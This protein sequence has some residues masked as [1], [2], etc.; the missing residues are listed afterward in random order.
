MGNPNVRFPGRSGPNGN[1]IWS[2]SIKTI[3]GTVKAARFGR[4]RP[5]HS[6]AGQ[7]RWGTVPPSFDTTTNHRTET[8]AATTSPAIDLVSDREDNKN[9]KDSPLSAKRARS[10]DT[11]PDYGQPH[12]A[13]SGRSSNHPAPATISAPPL[14]P[15]IEG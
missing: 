4:K 15:L 13:S 8:A 14:P 7:D 1:F 9:I 5:A 2:D 3:K 12:P 11:P 6:I 10:S